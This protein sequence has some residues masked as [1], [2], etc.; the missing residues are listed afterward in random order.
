M[1]KGINAPSDLVADLQIGPT[2]QGMVRIYVSGSGVDLPMD[3]APEEAEDIA[4]ELIASAEAARSA[5][6]SKD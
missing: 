1:A 5:A 6:S 2:D 3:F 4:A